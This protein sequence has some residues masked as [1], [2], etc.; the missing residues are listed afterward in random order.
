MVKKADDQPIS[1]II[2]T[3]NE[4]D[5]IGYLL[6]SLSR[7]THKNFEVIISDG[8]STDGTVKV[9]ESFS[10]QLPKLTI[11]VSKKRSPGIQRNR[12]EE[13]ARYER[14]LFLD[15]DTILPPDFVE[16]TLYEIREK[17]LSVAHPIAF[18]LTRKIVDHYYYIWRNWGLDLLQNIYPQA[19]GLAIFSAKKVHKAL[20]GFDERITKLGEDSDYVTR[21][22]KKGF[23]F[24]IIKSSN[25][26]I[27]VRR[28]EGQRKVS[29]GFIKEAIMPQ[30][31]I[32]LFGKYEAQKLIEREY[33]NH[34]NLYKV[35][36]EKKDKSGFLKKLNK[37]EFEKFTENLNKLLKEIT[38]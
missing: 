16:K 31:Y 29:L 30:I 23:K 26:Y 36:R 9:A 2:P 19:Q 8:N 12:G 13:K 14:L 21:A 17:K 38:S 18:P 33:G 1:I 22:Y 35:L 7:Q 15:A 5:F 3:L 10:K 25:V 24:G 32:L 28:A 27:S 6:F 20:L 11:V 37:T 34:S 4:A